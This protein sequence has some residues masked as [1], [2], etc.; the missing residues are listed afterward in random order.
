MERSLLLQIVDAA[1][2]DHLLAM[3]H[4][5]SSVGLAG[6]AQ[7]DP[8]VEYKREGMR[9]FEQMWT[10]MG[11]RVTDL[12][13][14]MEQLDEEFVGSTWVETSARHDAAQSASE[15]ASQQQQ[16][17]DA[18]QDVKIETIRHRGERVGRNDP[19]PCG[20]GKKYKQCCMRKST[21]AA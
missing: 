13:F 8:K 4:L 17:I 10:S 7:M 3:D 15:V 21:P 1:W 20:S 11:D 9:L 14:R 16:A 2:K 5:R 12:V 6:Y 18:S 19:C